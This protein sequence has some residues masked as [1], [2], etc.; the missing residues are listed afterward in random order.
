MKMP[1][2]QTLPCGCRLTYRIEGDGA[3]I[4]TVSPCQPTCD[5]PNQILG[6]TNNLNRPRDVRLIDETIVRMADQRN[7]DRIAINYDTVIAAADEP[8]P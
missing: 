2:D 1:D 3:H 4:M 7:P 8:T 6:L 5:T